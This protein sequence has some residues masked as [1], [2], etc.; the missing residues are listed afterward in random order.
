MGTLYIDRKELHVKLDGNALVFH[1]NDKR[2]GMVPIM[3][4]KRVV[5][6]GNITLETSVLNRLADHGIAVLFLS[7]RRM[8]FCGILHGRLHKNGILRVRQYEKSLSSFS[9]AFAREVVQ[10]KVN[11]QLSLLNDALVARPDRRFPLTTAAGSLR[12]IKDR[13]ES[14]VVEDGD[15]RQSGGEAVEGPRPL[16]TLTGLDGV[17]RWPPISLPS[18]P[19]FLRH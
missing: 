2:E 11:A 3:P 1:A 18:Q 14:L 10:S 13:L 4:L 19:F 6:V 16:G 17:P 7:G 15:G 9:L 5:V 8:R 12:A